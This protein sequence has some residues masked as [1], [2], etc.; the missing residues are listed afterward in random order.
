L[1]L[2]ALLLLAGCASPVAGG[3]PSAPEPSPTP[4]RLAVQSVVV[5][6]G[7]VW[8]GSPDD[9]AGRDADEHRVLV[10]V[11]KPFALGVREVDRALWR[12]VMGGDA[13]GR[14]TWGDEH[15]ATVSWMQAVAF[16]NALSAARGL[17]P[18]YVVEGEAVRW[19]P[20]SP[21]Y[22]LPTEAE[23]TLAASAGGTRY[24]GGDELAAVGWCGATDLQPVAGL[25]PNPLGFFDLTG[26]VEEWVWDRYS[27][28][29]P[30]VRVDPRGP[31][32]G[33]QR[34]ARG[35]NWGDDATHCR[36][37]DRSGFEPGLVTDSLGFR[38]A[39]N[40]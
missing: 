40:R 20:A 13:P 22:R 29:A 31:A 12:R 9:E 18:A 28:S 14:D 37:A 4:S 30:T 21:G 33:E 39:R 15:P 27:P 8:L 26:N 17:A 6:A 5:P 34:V 1:R 19:D 16:C 35:G 3:G 24:A 25:A 10:Q 38:V 2:L 7:S 23:W 32:A 11:T 36:L